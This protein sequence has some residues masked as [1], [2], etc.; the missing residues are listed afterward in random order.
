MNTVSVA[1]AIVGAYMYI[2]LLYNAL[3]W[4]YFVYILCIYKRKKCFCQDH[5]ISAVIAQCAV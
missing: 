3:L 4:I 1:A 5:K 2:R